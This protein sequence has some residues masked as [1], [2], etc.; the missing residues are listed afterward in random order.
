MRAFAS[1]T[2]AKKGAEFSTLQCDRNVR[3][4]MTARCLGKFVHHGVLDERDVRAAL[5]DACRANGAVDK[6]GIK[7]C[8]WTITSGL[9]RARN[10]A[11]PTLQD[12][13]WRPG[14]AGRPTQ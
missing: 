6:H 8:H 4:L 9:K 10:D 12:R 1:K 2:L 14:C 11:L 3:L 5:I 13:P 7:Q